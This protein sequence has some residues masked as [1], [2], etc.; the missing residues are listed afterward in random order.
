MKHQ[1]KQHFSHHHILLPLQLDEGEK[2][3]CKACEDSIIEPF[4]GCLS[5]KFYL[6]DS[7][8]EAPH[9]LGHPSH[10][11]HPLTLL[12][13]PTYPS[14]SFT[15]NAC[16]LEGN[17]FSYSC[18]RCEFDLH[19]Q[20]ACKPNALFVQN[21]PRELQMVFEFPYDDKSTPFACDL[22]NGII[23]PD[24][25]L[26]YCRACDFGKKMVSGKEKMS[27]DGKVGS[28]NSSLEKEKAI[29]EA[30]KKLREQRIAHKLMLEALDNACDYVGSSYTTRY[31]Y[32]L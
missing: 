5:C 2:I 15:C 16:I 24:K 29:F 20:C 12:P 30:Q 23:N 7:C 8:I 9:S 28:K 6:H 19:V 10:P 11:A 13:T 1:N 17:T 25:W 21:H 4:H 18:A 22:C 26:Y 31:D 27:G 3:N 14:R 32:Y